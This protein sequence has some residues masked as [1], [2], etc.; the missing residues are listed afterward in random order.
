MPRSLLILLL[1]LF[2][3]QNHHQESP[4]STTNHSPGV[5]YEVFVQAFADGDGDGIGD[6][7]GLTQK[8]S[9]IR[10]LG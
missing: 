8:L 4:L 7:I 3:C 5:V 6:L 2:A 9:Y 10:D 1:V